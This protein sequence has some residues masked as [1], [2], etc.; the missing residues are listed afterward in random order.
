MDCNQLVDV[1]LHTTE[2]FQ[3]ILMA[4]PDGYSELSN[5]NLTSYAMIKL[6]MYGGLYTQDIERLHRKT[7]SDKNIWAIFCQ[8]LISEY[9]KLLAEGGGT[10]LGQ[11]GYGT[12]LND[13]EST[14]D[15]TSITESIF[16]YAE[17]TTAAEEKVQA[18][19]DRLNKL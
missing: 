7:K 13:T 9:E 2:E 6:S 1:M 11:E 19:E 12:E 18:L 8:H 17:H 10:T 5:A 14:M 15:E 3:M 16:C 4:Y